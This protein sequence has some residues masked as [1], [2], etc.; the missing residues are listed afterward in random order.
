M[1]ETGTPEPGTPGAGTP[2]P[3][4]RRARLP[5]ATGRQVL[6]AL[7]RAVGAQRLLAAATLLLAAA[8]AL[9]G[10]VAP[11]AIGLLVD[12]VVGGGEPGGVVALIAWVAGAGVL[13]AALTAVSAAAVARIGQ[14]VL[15]RMREDVLGA[16]LRLPPGRL[17]ETGRGD[18]LARVGDDVG[19]VSQ[20]V[21]SLLAPW[22]GAA[23]AVT[24]TV[25]GLFALNPLLA[26]A[27]LTAIP[28]YVLALRWYLPRAAPRYGAER[29]AFGDRSEALVA[30]L[31]GLPTVHAYGAER[32][33]A[34]EIAASSHRARTI[35]R[36]V[37]WFATGWG[38][39]MN[40]AE[41]VGLGAI[42]AAG[43]GL[44]RA[45]AVTVGAVTAAALYFHRLFN[46]LGLIVF[47][48]DEMQSAGASL[49]RM[50]GVVIAGAGPGAGAGSGADD[51]PGARPPSPAGSGAGSG[52]DAGA[53]TGHSLP[54]LPAADRPAAADR[55]PADARPAGAVSVRGVGHRYGEHRVLREVSLEIAPGE[56]VALVGAS[57][58]G[59]P[60][61]P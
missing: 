54:G 28:V 11:W 26:L 33:H 49:Q 52:A 41:L 19:V 29:A 46:P 40:I 55:L 30:S 16:A 14:R 10:L 48:F 58:A 59:S 13:G 56:Q 36:D 2:E 34:A 12:E 61:S 5:L 9:A 42:I 3:G 27:G 38:K 37:L 31:S 50:V 35:S 25:A 17:E 51:A 20:V 23:L 6:R 32:E 22:V 57:G 8:A 53:G 60:R 18:L 21:A 7:R 15:A 44:V 43:F 39:W 24:L 4:T 1:T 45:D 47:S